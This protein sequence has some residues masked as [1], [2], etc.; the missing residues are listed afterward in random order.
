MSTLRFK[1][2]EE[3]FK[4]RPLEVKAPQER[5]SVQ[6]SSV[7]DLPAAPRGN[8]KRHTAASVCSQRRG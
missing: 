6:I 3:A 2:V 5:P 4:K 8:R 7:E 1:V